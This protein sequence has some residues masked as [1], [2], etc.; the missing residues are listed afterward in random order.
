MLQQVIGLGAQASQVQGLIQAQGNLN[1]HLRIWLQCW[2]ANL[3]SRATV[4]LN[5]LPF[6]QL[7]SS[8]RAIDSNLIH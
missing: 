3:P 7:Q 1:S 4:L 2:G 6:G 5:P 8:H